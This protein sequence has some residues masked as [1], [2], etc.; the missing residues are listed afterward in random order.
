MTQKKQSP[1]RNRLITSGVI[2]AASLGLAYTPLPGM[3]RT[4]VVVSGSE[5]QEPLQALETKFEQQ[6]PDIKLEL[7]FQGSQDIANQ[8]LNQKQDFTPA[9]LIPAN[10]ETIAEIKDRWLAGNKDN[11]FDGD[12]KPIA[13]TRLVAVSWSDR[14]QTLFPDGQFRWQRLEQAMQKQNWGAIATNRS[15]WGSFD[16]VMTDPARSN[17]GQLIMGLW[18]QTKLGQPLT[19]AAVNQPPVQQ[20]FKLVKQSVYQPKRSTDDMLKE[21]IAQG[22]NQG[23]L[24]IAYESNALYRLQQSAKNQ[25]TPYQIYYLETTVETVSTAAIVKRDVDWGTAD[26]AKQFVNFL[27]QPEQQTVFVQYGFRPVAGNLDLQSVPNSPWS[28]NL[29]GVQINPPGQVI[30]SPNWETQTEVVRQWERSQ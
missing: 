23:D 1:Q 14:G 7:K 3:Q 11:P 18:A 4:L 26:A 15:N 22:A 13:K 2:L 29:P 27:T 10:A 6:Y 24:A 9:V 17:S 28:Q 20:L 5:L 25:T 21:F 12:P 30:A 8:F 16:F 19:N